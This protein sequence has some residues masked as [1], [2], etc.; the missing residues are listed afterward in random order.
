MF[1]Y[2]QL[3]KTA[4]Q[5][6]NTIMQRSL[7]TKKVFPVA[8]GYAI[9]L[10]LSLPTTAVPCGYEYFAKSHVRQAKDTL[11]I[12]NEVML[13]DVDAALE[14]I[15]SF[16]A[17]R[18]AMAYAETFPT[19]NI[20]T[21]ENNIPFLSLLRVAEFFSNDMVETIN[22]DCDK[23]LLSTSLVTDILKNIEEVATKETAIRDATATLTG[24]QLPNQTFIYGAQA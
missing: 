9:A 1:T 10:R 4:V 22:Q 19:I 2:S 20:S 7:N 12:L 21:K 24:E 13:F 18:L 17:H 11:S 23:F 3:T 15:K 5:N 6:V 14:A 8:V 16:F